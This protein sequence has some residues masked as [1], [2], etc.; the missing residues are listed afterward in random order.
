MPKTKCSN[1]KKYNNKTPKITHNTRKQIAQPY[2]LPIIKTPTSF[3]S[4]SQEQLS[5]IIFL[6]KL[7]EFDCI[8][9]FNG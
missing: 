9:K 4:T 7:C 5:K 2:N 6:N 1:N 3:E 8:F